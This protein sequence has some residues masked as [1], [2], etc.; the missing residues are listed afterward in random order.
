MNNMSKQNHRERSQFALNQTAKAVPVIVLMAMNPS[1]LNADLPKTEYNPNTIEITT[2]ETV[3]NLEKTY[4]LS[5]QQQKSKLPRCLSDDRVIYKKRFKAEGQN[6]TMYYTNV[7]KNTQKNYVMSV[8][9]V[10]D[11]YRQIY[12][13]D[14]ELNTTP[15]IHHL[16]YHKTG[17]ETEFIGAVTKEI[18]AD[19]HKLKSVTR[20][21]RLPDEIA[22]ELT[23]LLSEET[24]FIPNKYQVKQFKIV[25]TNEMEPTIVKDAK[26]RNTY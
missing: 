17:P 2:P 18:T 5:T 12:D 3:Q 1:L 25:D 23:A 19:N 22:N 14:Y 24:E 26:G 7:N 11:S 13:G 20:E 21:M 16:V 4:M 8:Y 10:P 6:W 9:L 15:I